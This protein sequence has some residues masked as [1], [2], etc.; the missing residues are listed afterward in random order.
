MNHGYGYNFGESEFAEA[1]P[2]M[3]QPEAKIGGLRPPPNLTKTCAITILNCRTQ[4]PLAC[5]RPQIPPTRATWCQKTN[6]PVC[7]PYTRS[8]ICTRT[9]VGCGW[10]MNFPCPGADGRA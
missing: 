8:L 2:P 5:Q 6:P 9:K 1:P 4:N 10:T 7:V 3:A